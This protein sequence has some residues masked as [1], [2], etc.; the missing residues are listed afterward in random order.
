MSS[1]YI[2][3]LGRDQNLAKLEIVSILKQA[4]F[5]YEIEIDGANY[6]VI[7]FKDKLNVNALMQRLAG[8]V[9]IAEVFSEP[10]GVTLQNFDVDLDIDIDKLDIYFPNKQ[11]ASCSQFSI[12]NS[13]PLHKTNSTHQ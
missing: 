6:L 9:R 12:P 3:V 4:E 8:T 13:S 5:D 10:E 1:K 7:T 11:E 2:F